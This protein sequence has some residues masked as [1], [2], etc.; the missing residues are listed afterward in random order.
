MVVGKRCLNVTA[1]HD[2]KRKLIDNSCRSGIAT[3][4]RLPGQLPLFRRR[5]KHFIPL[6]QRLAKSI[7]FAAIRA[8]GGRVAAFQQ[9]IGRRDKDHSLLS[10]ILECG[11][12][13]IVPLV[14][15]VP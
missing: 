3:M 14:R 7:Y 2:R 12:R 8:S 10:E 6:F 1:A 15:N 5:D 11:F 13:G 4:I 9:D